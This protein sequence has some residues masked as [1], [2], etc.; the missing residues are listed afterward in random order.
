MDSNSAK[1]LEI[2]KICKKCGQDKPLSKFKK[3]YHTRATHTGKCKDC[4][5]EDSRML[6]K[7]D[8]NKGK[9]RSIRW[10]KLNPDRFAEFL[11]KKNKNKREK[12]KEKRLSKGWFVNDISEDILNE[13]GK[14]CLGGKKR[15]Q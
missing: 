10:Q 11:K 7:K 6:W 12:T 5:N 14:I 4:I 3:L 15:L 13:N 8:P 9:Q 1:I 2:K